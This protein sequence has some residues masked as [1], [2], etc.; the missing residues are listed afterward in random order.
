MRRLILLA[1]IAPIGVGCQ[2]SRGGPDR[3]QGLRNVVAER[4]DTLFVA[5]GETV[6]D[7]LFAG[8]N[9]LAIADGV[10]VVGDDMAARLVALD[11]TTGEV[12]WRFG[13]PGAGPREFRGLADIAVTR[14]G[15]IWVL[16]FGNGRI[17]ELSST[18]EF[19][20]VRTLHHLPAPPASI[21]PLADRAIAMSHGAPEPFM[22]IGLDS[23][24]LRGAFTLAWPEPIPEIANTRVELAEGPGNVWVSAFALG[25][26]FTVW[27]RGGPSSY[28]YRERVPFANRSSREIRRLRADSARNGA[29]SLDVVGEEIFVLFGGRPVRQAHPG[30]PTLWIDVYSLDGEYVRSYRLPFD[31]SAMAT[32]GQ[33]FYLHP[34]EGVPRLIGLRPIGE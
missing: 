19:R 24:E 23:L 11:R 32:D 22:E 1:L 14:G 29:M 25:P 3:S 27:G 13:G 6:N 15:T 10:V 9:Q 8:P 20:G 31:T 5:G 4:W 2:E 16:D 28:H 34:A 30:E 7:T 26:G 33:T 17:A 21:L 18:G 12:E